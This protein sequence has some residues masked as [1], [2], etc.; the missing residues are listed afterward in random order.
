MEYKEYEIV[1]EEVEFYRNLLIDYL[2]E[3]NMLIRELKQGNVWIEYH[4]EKNNI[5]EKDI[6]NLNNEISNLKNNIIKCEV[7]IHY[8]MVKEEVEFFKHL[9]INGLKERNMLIRELKQ[10]NKLIE[11]Y[12]EKNIALVKEIDNLNNEI[13]SLKTTL[14]IMNAF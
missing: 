10:N 14:A 12:E 11:Q 6:E 13:G 7:Y 9:I 8:K 3:R 2:K 4:M 1:E 5:L